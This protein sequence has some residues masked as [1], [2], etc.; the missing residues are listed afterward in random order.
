M[1]TGWGSKT[2]VNGLGDKYVSGV[3]AVGSTIYAATLWGL[4]FS[5]ALAASGPDI[6]MTPMQAYG[7]DAD[8]KCINNAP[9]RVNW[10]VN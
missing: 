3:Y 6:P 2:T 10:S 9:E 5:A 1:V 8:G 4:S 7:R